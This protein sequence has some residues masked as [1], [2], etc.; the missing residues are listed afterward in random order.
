M[1]DEEL[2]LNFIYLFKP[3][4]NDSN[5][6]SLFEMTDVYHHS[7]K[8][9]KHMQKIVMNEEQFYIKMKELITESYYIIDPEINNIIDLFKKNYLIKKSV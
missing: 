1:N 8:E 7:K 4:S 2:F 9:G 6:A 3:P 5:L